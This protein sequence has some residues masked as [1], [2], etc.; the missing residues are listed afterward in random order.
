MK[1]TLRKLNFKKL[2]SFFLAAIAVTMF[3]SCSDDDGQNANT[4]RVVVHMTDAPGDYDHVYVDVQDVRIKADASTSDDEGWVSL[5][6][7]Q[8]GEYDLLSLTN[9]VTQLLADSE[10]PVGNLGQIRLVLGPDNFVVLNDGIDDNPDV[11]IPLSTPSAQQSGLK[12]NVNQQMEAG[13]L[14]EYLLDFDVDQSIVITGNG[15]YI[16]KP[17]IRLSTIE[18][19]GKIEGNVLPTVGASGDF[20]IKVTATN[21]N[22]TISAYTNANGGFVLHGVPAGTYRVIFTPEPTSG[23]AELE[24]INVQ[25]ASGAVVE[26]G[27]IDLLEM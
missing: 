19:S 22:H 7:V 25:V 16:L 6:N 14:Y 18:G 3:Y 17:V 27:T 10:V 11:R 20:Q 1:M 12:L 26:L 24:K 13:E 15:G 5:G 23:Y 21:A 8:K 2:T 4:A 9:G